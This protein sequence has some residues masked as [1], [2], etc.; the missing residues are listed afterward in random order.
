[1]NKSHF[2]VLIEQFSI[3]QIW[4]MQNKLQRDRK[5]IFKSNQITFLPNFGLWQYI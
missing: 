2:D 3:Y 1:M 5:L 4:N